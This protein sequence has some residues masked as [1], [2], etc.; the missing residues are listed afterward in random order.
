MTEAEWLAC[1]DPMQ[2]LGALKDNRP[3]RKLRLLLCAF[4]RQ[5]WSLFDARDFDNRGIELAERMADDSVSRKELQATRRGAL[6]GLIDEMGWREEDADFML[7]R[8]TGF[9]FEDELV[10][11]RRMVAQLAIVRAVAETVSVRHL[12]QVLRL[13]AEAHAGASGREDCALIRD[14][15]EA[16]F[17]P[18]TFSDAWRTDTALVLARQMYDARDFSAMPILA[19]A[20]Q[21]AGCDNDDIL[22][23]CRTERVHVRGCWVADHVLGKG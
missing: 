13:I 3:N 11:V 14:I 17:R 2:M 16:P 4:C 19:D 22:N 23:H 5:S 10:W 18:V 15:F 8:F 7:D 20:L 9:H 1:E 12:A 6:V 21:D